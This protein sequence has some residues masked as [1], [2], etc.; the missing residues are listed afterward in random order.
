MAPVL[1]LLS[2]VAYGAADFLGGMAARK[3]T[4]VAAVVV[5]QTAGLILLLL[6][7]PLLP[8]TIVNPID[9]AW[10]AVAGLAGGSGV[11]LLY[12]ALALGPMSVVAPLTAVFA[13]AV[14]VFTGLALGERLSMVTTLGIALAAIAIVLIGQEQGSVPRSLTQQATARGIT[15]SI[16]AGLLVG[17]FFVS[18]ERTSAAS[19]LWPLVPARVV[20]IS[21]FTGSALAGGRPVLVPWSVAGVAVGAGALDMLANALFLIAVQQGPLSVVATLASLYPASTI[22]LARIVLG[23][24]WSRLQAAGIATAVAATAMIV[25]GIP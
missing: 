22:I 9:I 21:L 11:A 7:L 8:E 2:A 16:V 23:E 3:A 20:A 13:A 14:P 15:L 25:G 19:G 12:R 5:S 1:A 18:L 4:A 17:V 24:R 10:G 6:A